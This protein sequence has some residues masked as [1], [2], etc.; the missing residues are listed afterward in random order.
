[1]KTKE[2]FRL[3]AYFRKK[4]K[5]FIRDINGRD[6][7]NRITAELKA[8]PSVKSFDWFQLNK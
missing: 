6:Q 4:S 7:L 3:F 8:D 1:M 2:R 5:N